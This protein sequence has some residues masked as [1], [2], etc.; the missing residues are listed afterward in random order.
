VRT[1]LSIDDDVAKLLDREVRRTGDS[2]KATVN[3]LIRLGFIASRDN[4]RTSEP[5][6]VTPFS[7]GLKPGLSYDSISDLLEEIEG[8]YQR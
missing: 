5:F 6:V 8:P 2:L 3:R 1:T 7:L 4:G